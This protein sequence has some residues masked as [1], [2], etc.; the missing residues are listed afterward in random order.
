MGFRDKPS[1]HGVQMDTEQ[2]QRLRQM[3]R[4]RGCISD[5]EVQLV[6]SGALC[7]QKETRALWLYRGKTHICDR[8][9]QLQHY[10]RGIRTAERY[11][12]RHIPGLQQLQR[13]V[14]CHSQT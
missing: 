6:A 11:N 8:T 9:V 4:R 2:S 14:H 3:L 10:P 12:D 1:R 5:T 7:V 13:D